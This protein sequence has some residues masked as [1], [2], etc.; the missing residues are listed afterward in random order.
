MSHQAATLQHF[1]AAQRDWYER[2]RLELRNG[3]KESNW[4]SFLFPHIEI[5]AAPVSKEH[6]QYAIH[7]REEAEAYLADYTLGSR[8]KE[9]AGILLTHPHVPV[10]HLMGTE[11]DAMK[12]HSSMTLFSLFSPPGS[13]F[14]RVLSQFFDG[15]RCRWTL[16][17]FSG[18]LTGKEQQEAEEARRQLPPQTQSGR[19]GSSFP[20]APP[21]TDAAAESGVAPFPR[22]DELERSLTYEWTIA[23]WV[24]HS[25]DPDQNLQSAGRDLGIWLDARDS[26]VL[27]FFIRFERLCSR[28]RFFF[29]IS[30]CRGVM[31]APLACSGD[32]LVSKSRPF[33]DIHWEVRESP[34]W[35]IDGALRLRFE[36][37][38][39]FLYHFPLQPEP[40]NF[41][42]LAPTPSP[43]LNSLI[44]LIFQAVPLRVLVCAHPDCPLASL[45]RD[46]SAVP[47]DLRIPMS[48]NVSGF[49]YE[50]VADCLPTDCLFR[51]ALDWRSFTVMPAD[52]FERYRL[53]GIRFREEPAYLC[54]ESAGRFACLVRGRDGF[55][56]RLIGVIARENGG[57]AAYARDSRDDVFLRVQGE[58]VARFAFWEVEEVQNS[59]LLL[60]ARTP[61]VR[62]M[63][64]V[65]AMQPMPLLPRSEAH[66][67]SAR[68]VRLLLPDALVKAFALGVLSVGGGTV[69][70][71]NLP[72]G[73]QTYRELSG[74]VA[75]F[76]ESFDR[77]F[78][79]YPVTADGLALPPDPEAEIGG[80]ALFVRFCYP[81]EKPSDFFVFVVGF[82]ATAHQP[83]LHL[84]FTSAIDPA[85]PFDEIV[86]ISRERMPRLK[87]V[88]ITITVFVP[89]GDGVEQIPDLATPMS[90]LF[91]APG[92]IVILQ[93]D[94]PPDMELCIP[95]VRLL[96]LDRDFACWCSPADAG[97]TDVASYLDWRRQ[98]RPLFIG[99]QTS[100]YH[101]SVPPAAPFQ[102]FLAFL[103]DRLEFSRDNCLALLFAGY[104]LHP[105]DPAS[106]DSVGNLVREDAVLELLVL[107]LVSATAIAR[108]VRVSLFVREATKAARL[109]FSLLVPNDCPL[110]ELIEM[111]R[112]KG[113]FGE[114]P[115]E[116]AE[117][118]WSAVELNDALLPGRV[119]ER[120]AGLSTVTAPIGLDY[121]WT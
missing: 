96:D 119:L 39:S 1:L 2:A 64:A 101:F 103:A 81:D 14:H 86:A 36:F 107:P 9:L 55:E 80:A 95:T 3:H 21:E 56:Y 11:L 104:D 12:L 4:I 74:C 110:A 53:K 7:Y 106:M 62:P 69:T 94:R 24:T 28:L 42:R 105:I 99:T 115:W 61:L 63:R 70:S 72:E 111:G 113:W 8:L 65:P 109:Q 29:T 112:S 87:S 82:I 100:A 10:N 120:D 59:A 90:D 77:P 46:P 45:F 30:I 102:L 88:A 116:A 38:S 6:A 93:I 19:F 15:Q 78:L 40:L 20:D 26:R 79:L 41:V 37:V 51:G 48:E 58:S 91:S 68:V 114:A 76:L 73:V 13:V 84:L 16:K 57:W 97:V 43:L 67:P 18:L 17:K 71:L 33:A 5:E 35:L 75:T 117:L 85:S 108:L 118:A 27:K 49:T 34:D 98:S 22:L 52:D 25:T 44:R 60:Y 32:F 23:D 50:F 31:H 54:A 66:R 47:P 92:G 83:P 121:A 89:R